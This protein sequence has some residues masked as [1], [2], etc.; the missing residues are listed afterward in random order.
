MC[1]TKLRSI[2]F[3]VGGA[4]NYR[5][6][7]Q[8]ST[9]ECKKPKK[10]S[11]LER[12]GKCA[13]LRCGLRSF[14]APESLREIGECAFLRCSGLEN[15]YLNDGLKVIGTR[16]FRGVPA[17]EIELPAGVETTGP[18]IGTRGPVFFSRVVAD[19]KG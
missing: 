17:D 15:V 3:S 10:K 7:R 6:T 11:A 12:I 5:N 1:C 8:I 19:N 9:S 2:N 4:K 16:C 13:F 14:D 18:L